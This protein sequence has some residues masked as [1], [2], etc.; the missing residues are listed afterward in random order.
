MMLV[1]DG[2]FVLW[3]CIGDVALVLFV[4]ILIKSSS[5]PMSCWRKD[6]TLN[7]FHP[8]LQDS[9]DLAVDGNVEV[10]AVHPSIIG[11]QY[12]FVISNSLETKYFSCRSGE[13][14]SKWVVR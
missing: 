14:M 7:L 6:S 8:F 3:Y 11:H 5:L 2:G 13:E 1:V 4:V 12:C 9:V 10:R